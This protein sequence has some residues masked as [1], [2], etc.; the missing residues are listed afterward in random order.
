MV[1][2]IFWRVACNKRG[3][4]LSELYEWTRIWLQT[5][6]NL[7]NL[8]N[9]YCQSS[10]DEASMHFF[11]QPTKTWFSGRGPVKFC[12]HQKRFKGRSKLF[13]FSYS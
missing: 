1:I 8:C 3:F 9:I 10:T 13:R 6:E 11:R 2:H 12:F 7:Y 4:D 5:R